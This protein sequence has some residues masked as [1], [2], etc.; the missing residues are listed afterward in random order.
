MDQERYIKQLLKDLIETVNI[1]KN[2]VTDIKNDVTYIKTK[3]NEINENH[4]TILK[5]SEKL[6][7][8]IDFVEETYSLIKRPMN[9]ILDSVNKITNNNQITN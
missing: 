6:D 1:I 4:T 5:S 7:R 3:L 8:H 9:Y 2:D